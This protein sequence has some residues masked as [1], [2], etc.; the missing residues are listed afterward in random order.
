[1]QRS[2]SITRDEF[3]AG[4]YLQLLNCGLISGLLQAGVFNPWDRALNLSVKHERPF[5]RMENFKNPM[6]GVF[7][8]IFQ[9]AVSTGLYFPLEDI[10]AHHLQK[11]KDKSNMHHVLY[12]GD[13]AMLKFLA[14]T[15][16]GACNGVMMNPI[17]SIKVWKNYDYFFRK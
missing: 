9:R 7:Q 1:M 4:K 5:L 16:A 6:A 13:G 11:M 14:G 3:S 2:S 12:M 15:L 17:A 8:T 10:F